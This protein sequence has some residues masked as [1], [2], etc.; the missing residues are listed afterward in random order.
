MCCCC[1]YPT[2]T[3]TTAAVSAEQKSDTNHADMTRSVIVDADEDGNM[4]VIIEGDGN[5]ERHLKAF[6]YLSKIDECDLV[7]ACFHNELF[8]SP[9]CVCL[10]HHQKS[11]VITIRGTLSMR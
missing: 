2:M 1:Y 5:L 11:I 8:F 10:D 9:F 3:P 6:K 4:N 7:Y